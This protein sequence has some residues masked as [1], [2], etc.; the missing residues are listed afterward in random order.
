MIVGVHAYLYIWLVFLAFCSDDL[1]KIALYTDRE[2]L[3]LALAE[4][5]DDA[6]VVSTCRCLVLHLGLIIFMQCLFA[7]TL[8]CLLC[9]REPFL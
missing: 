7:I 4:D 5:A 2:K 1:D 3:R 8:H 9:K 6:Q